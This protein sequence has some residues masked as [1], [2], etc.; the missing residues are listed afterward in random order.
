[1][2]RVMPIPPSKGRVMG[3]V[4]GYC[5]GV[6]GTPVWG[7]RRYGVALCAPRGRVLSRSCNACPTHTHNHTQ[8]KRKPPI[9][10]TLDPTHMGARAAFPYRALHVMYAHARSAP[11]RGT[12][13]PK[14]IT[15][16]WIRKHVE[17]LRQRC[18]T[19][20]RPRSLRCYAPEQPHAN[21]P[22]VHAGGCLPP[23]PLGSLHR[24]HLRGP[25]RRQARVEQNPGVLHPHT[26]GRPPH[27]HARGRCP[28]H[29][30]AHRERA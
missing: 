2:G 16:Q 28:S 30:P 12:E 19:H 13:G 18:P 26:S 29:G 10:A 17:K 7:G 21:V 14:Y 3:R 20:D 5:G 27:P 24:D 22:C 4:M 25:L 9:Q 1:M 11:N 8:A 23:L 15:N 6:V